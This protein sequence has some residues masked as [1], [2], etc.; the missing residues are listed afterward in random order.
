MKLKKKAH[1]MFEQT[2]TNQCADRD[3]IVMLKGL[4][5]IRGA[6]GTPQREIPTRSDDLVTIPMAYITRDFSSHDLVGHVRNFEKTL[7]YQ[8]RLRLGKAK[9]SR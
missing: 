4:I 3:L 6:H 5:R 2:Y 8:C 9:K 7:G 1:R